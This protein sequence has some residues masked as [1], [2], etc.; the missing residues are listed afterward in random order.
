M[1][2]KI[3]ILQTA[4]DM[5]KSGYIPN[6]EANVQDGMCKLIPSNLGAVYRELLGEINIIG[7]E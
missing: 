3:L 1:G 2:L 7:F 6:S 5:I 4:I